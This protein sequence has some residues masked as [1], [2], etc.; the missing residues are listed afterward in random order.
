MSFIIA[1]PFITIV[2]ILAVVI[3]WN[4]INEQNYSKTLFGC[5][6]GIAT[7]VIVR[8]FTKNKHKYGN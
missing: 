2:F 5:V 8:Y 6:L 7:A 3:V 4:G 1:F